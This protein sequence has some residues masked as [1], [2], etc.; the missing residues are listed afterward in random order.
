MTPYQSDLLYDITNS[1][2][3][4]KAANGNIVKAKKQGTVLIK[5]VDVHTFEDQ[6][7]L[8]ETVLWVPGLNRRLFSVPQWNNSAGD[9]SFSQGYCILSI[10]DSK[11]ETI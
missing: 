7:I 11:G 1:S 8:L 2:T 4:I 5:I 6:D 10:N 3:L 9:I